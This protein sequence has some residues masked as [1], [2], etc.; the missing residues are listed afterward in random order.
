MSR[1]TALSSFVFRLFFL[2]ACTSAP[3]L[4]RLASPS[5]RPAPALR[6]HLSSSCI[7]ASLVNPLSPHP[8]VTFC[9][10]CLICFSPF[11]HSDASRHMY[12]QGQHRRTE[13]HLSCNL[14]GC[15]SPFASPMK[16]VRRSSVGEQGGTSTS[17][18]TKHRNENAVC[19]IR[20]SEMFALYSIY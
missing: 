7:F 15:V 9:C 18:N 20:M 6:D 19:P 5:I 16:A 12:G 13:S 11:H 4:S 14:Q 2:G 8:I 17:T 1:L 3:S 10:F